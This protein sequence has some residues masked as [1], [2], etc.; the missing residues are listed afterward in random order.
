[1]KHNNFFANAA[2]KALALAAT[3]MMMSAAFTACSK[4]NNEPE[5]QPTPKANTVTLDGAERPIV[6]AE[7]KDEGDGDYSLYLY[8]SADRK[9]KVKFELNK[10]LHITGS[11]IDLTKKEKEHDEWYWSVD[12]YKPGDTEL[13]N[14]FGEPGSSTPVFTT[15]TLTVSGSP[16]STLNIKLENG[17]VMGEDGNEHTLTVS[18]SGKMEK[19]VEPQPEPKANTVTLDGTKKSIVKAEYEDK[20]DDN[21]ILH[22]YLSDD[23]KERVSFEL[24]KDLHITGNPIDLTKKEAEHDGMWYWGV[25]YYGADGKRIIHTYGIPENSIPVFTT[26]TLTMSGDPTGTI[27]IKLENGRVKGKDGKEHTIILNYNGTMEKKKDTPQPEPKANTVTLDGT[28]KPI[29]KAK[30]D[31]RGKGNYWLYLYLSADGKE[32]VKIELNKDLHMTGSPINLTKREEE[33]D[34]KWYWSVMYY[35]PDDTK[36]IYTYG[37]PDVTTYPVFTTGTLTVSGSPTGT[38]NIKLENGRVK[39]TDGKEHTIT[40]SYNGTMEKKKD[41]PQPEPKANTV[42]LDGTN[43]P[44]VKA[45]YDD[46]GKGNYWL[47]LYLSA[48]GKEKVKIELNKDLHMTGSPI[49]LTKREEEHDGKW[50]WSVM[51]YKP[52]DTKLIYTYGGPDVTTYPVFTTGTL[53]VSGSPTGTIN[54]KLENGRVKGTDGK[55]HTITLNYNGKMTKKE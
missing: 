7:Y 12:Y 34:G 1:M 48:D 17:R 15:G 39:G 30:Y 19:Y 5:P 13:I 2:S 14:T 47:Y 31:D 22:F 25:D 51:Y 8:L 20:Y 49:N 26:G 27:N 36:L 54:I 38:I 3:V 46:R 45:K 10:D 18:Y 42:T 28:N 53:T 35:K 9:E 44:I 16:E 55:E 32:K 37:G 40:V 41:T 23:G 24:N 29:V 6:K 4:E 52:D 50:Y 43:K 21:Y 33:H 11:P